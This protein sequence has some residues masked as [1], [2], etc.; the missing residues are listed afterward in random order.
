MDIDREMSSLEKED[1]LKYVERAISSRGLKDL[2]RGNYTSKNRLN[3]FNYERKKYAVF[4]PSKISNIVLNTFR[5]YAENKWNDGFSTIKYCEDPLIHAIDLHKQLEQKIQIPK[6]VNSKI[7]GTYLE[8]EVLITQIP[9]GI[10]D[11]VT[12]SKEFPNTLSR[13][14]GKDLANMHNENIAYRDPSIYT[15]SVFPK[16]HMISFNN[17]A[18]AQPIEKPE[19][20]ARDIMQ[21]I[22]SLHYNSGKPIKVLTQFFGIFYNSIA[23]TKNDIKDAMKNVIEYDLEHKSSNPLRAIYQWTVFGVGQD[24]MIKLKKNILDNYP[25]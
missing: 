11:A 24:D 12:Y 4:K 23:K 13:Y 19:D 17:F 18:F 20:K 2:L 3:T 14:I 16:E 21:F 9:E 10:V 22:I 1:F 15:L 8:D 6:I 5:Q 7:D 25:I